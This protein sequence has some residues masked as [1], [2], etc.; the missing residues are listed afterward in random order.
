[1]FVAYIAVA[2]NVASSP[3]LIRNED[4]ERKVEAVQ[5]GPPLFFCSI[6]ALFAAQENCLI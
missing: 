2:A 3:L 6:A 1:M 4:R 5:P